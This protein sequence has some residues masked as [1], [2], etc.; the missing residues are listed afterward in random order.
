MRPLELWEDFQT[1]RLLTS[2]P[3]MSQPTPSASTGERRELLT[4]F[5]TKDNVVPAGPSPPLL[6]WRVLTSSSP[7]LFSSSPSLNSLIAIPNVVVAMEVWK[8]TLSN[9]LCPTQWSS[10]LLTHTL[11]KLDLANL[12]NLRELSEL[13][14]TLLSDTKTSLP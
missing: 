13:H 4:Q 2:R 3:T 6:P 10:K 8:P 1:P 11:L 7:D 9:M 14:P 5:K 12:A